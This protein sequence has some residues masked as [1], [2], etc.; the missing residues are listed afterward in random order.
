MKPNLLFILTLLSVVT[1]AET[2][3]SFYPD[4]TI[5]SVIT[6]KDGKKNG[7]EHAFYA[8]GATLK[9][10]KNYAYGKLHGTQQQYS[11]NALLIQEESYKHGR[12]DGRSRFYRDGLL[13]R[14]VEY[15]HGMV[16]GTYREFYPSGLVKVKIIWRR[17]R[18]VEGYE[19]S[20]IGTRTP[21]NS[22]FLQNLQSKDIPA[23]TIK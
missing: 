9:Y 22:K 1:F 20:E 15:T 19:Y 18:A 14:E 17:N 4:G 11:Q 13:K 2:D 16:D 10:A 21:L 3:K 5:K 8:D 7:V 23:S 6:Y 12:L